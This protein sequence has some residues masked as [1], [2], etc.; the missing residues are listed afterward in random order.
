MSIGDSGRAYRLFGHEAP[1]EW[2]NST[3]GPETDFFHGEKRMKI[4]SASAVIIFAAV[5]AVGA[6]IIAFVWAKTSSN[7]R[8][9]I[10]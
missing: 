1:E 7:R 3:I 4:D 6:L 9:S 10:A 8:T 2:L 5:F